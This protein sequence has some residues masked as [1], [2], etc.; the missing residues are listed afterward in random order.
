MKIKLGEE[1]EPIYDWY[2]AYQTIQTYSKWLTRIRRTAL[3]PSVYYPWS[4]NQVSRSARITPCIACQTLHTRMYRFGNNHRK[5]RNPLCLCERCF[6]EWINDFRTTDIIK[7]ERNQLISDFNRAIG[8]EN[9]SEE[10]KQEIHN[11]IS[12]LVVYYPLNY[13]DNEMRQL[14]KRDTEL[15]TELESIVRGL[16]PN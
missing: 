11:I 15:I 1:E 5:I 14:I 4:W 12:N 2:V 9:I 3:I 8:Q 10:M 16:K 6:H 13:S 7:R